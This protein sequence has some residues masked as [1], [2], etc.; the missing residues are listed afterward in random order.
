MSKKIFKGYLKRILD[1]FFQGLLFITPIGLT[2]FILF[3]VFDFA[4]SLVQNYIADLLPFKIPGL[5]I[6]LLFIIISIFGYFGQRLISKPMTIIFEKMLKKAPFIEMVY[7]S[8]KDFLSAFVGK[9]K[10]FKQPVLVKINPAA[11]IEKIG[12]ITETDLKELNAI[13]KVAVYL[14]WSYTFTG[15]LIIVPIEQVTPIDISSTEA[16]KFVVSG[17]VSKM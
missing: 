4:D 10:K 8:I 6:I 2:I 17:G 16:M 1:N 7:S 15:E 5:G 3:K 9:E 14:P 11:N 13:G 12:F